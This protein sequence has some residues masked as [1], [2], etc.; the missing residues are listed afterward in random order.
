MM[1]MDTP[2]TPDERAADTTALLASGEPLATGSELARMLGVSR[3]WIDSARFAAYTTAHPVRFFPTPR[4]VRYCVAD[5]RRALDAR[6]PYLEGK[7]AA[8]LARDAANVAAD[9]AAAAA[10]RE[11]R[12]EAARQRDAKKTARSKAHTSRLPPPKVTPKAPAPVAPP[13][14]PRAP[15]VFVRRRRAG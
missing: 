13:S 11:A 6:R 1:P 2:R 14:P 15:E 10:R 3:K 12:Q 8:G 5:M 4:P 7:L 9:K